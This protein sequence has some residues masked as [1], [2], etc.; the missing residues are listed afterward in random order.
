MKIIDILNKMANGTLENGF[1]FCLEDEVYIYTKGDNSIR[2]K[3]HNKIGQTKI[4]ETYLNK[5]VLLFKDNNQE[6]IEENK[7]IEELNKISYD[8]FKHTDTKH[9]FD[10]TNI[11]YDKI[12]ELVR[13]VNK[14]N[15]DLEKTQTLN[16]EIDEETINNAIKKARDYLEREEK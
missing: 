10:L 6:V 7:E 5:E 12:N 13:A 8:E 1:K 11:E 14:I 9:R 15:K 16:I 2:D 3:Y 4:I